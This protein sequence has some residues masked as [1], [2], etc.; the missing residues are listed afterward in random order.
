VAVLEVPTGNATVQR[1]AAAGAE[2]EAES[3]ERVARRKA[4]V[5]IEA[6]AEV[7]A[8]PKG[9]WL[10]SSCSP[11]KGNKQLL[12][13]TKYALEIISSSYTLMDSHFI[14]LGNVL[15]MHLLELVVCPVK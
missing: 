5:V 3:E 4:H 6:G 13:V 11:D 9:K 8:R 12:I 14:R 15:S 1:E 10:E 7:L 2:V